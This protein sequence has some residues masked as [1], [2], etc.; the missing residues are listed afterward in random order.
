M[1]LGVCILS[2]TFTAFLLFQSGT[3][4]A[5][6]WVIVTGALSTLFAVS[7]I[8]PQIHQTWRTKEIGALS[9]SSVFL[10]ILG[11]SGAMAV[12]IL[13]HGL[14][15]YIVWISHCMCAIL[16]LVL[17]L[18]CLVLIYCKPRNKN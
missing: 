10:Q 12:L 15:A 17:V 3:K 18:L 13:D 16:E 7:K 11:S 8:I 9:L 2:L 4:L 1:V 5:R 6:V 14:S